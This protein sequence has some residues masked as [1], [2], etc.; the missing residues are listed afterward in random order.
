MNVDTMRLVD[1]WV[2]APLCCLLSGWERMARA[3]RRPGEKRPIQKI[4]F[5][6]LS[7]MG[8]TVSAYSAIKKVQE[9]FPAAQLY[10]LMFQEMQESIRL[11]SI[12]A[13]QHILT[14]PSK[15]LS[16]L[17]IGLLRM[18]VYLRRQRFDAVL[19]LE[20]FARNSTII[21]YLSGARLRVGFDAFHMEGLYR[22]GLL[23]HRVLYNH[24]QHISRNFLG[25]AQALSLDPADLPLAKIKINPA[26]ICLP[27]IASTPE[28]KQKMRARL[29]ALCPELAV[30]H[31][32]IVFNPNG[33]LLL[34]L[35]RWPMQSYVELGKRL[36]ACPSVALV[37]TGTAAER[38]DAD[39]ICGAVR[40]SRCIN[41]AGQTTLRE[42]ID[43][44]NIA[45]LLVSNDSGPPNFASLTALKVL[46]FFGPETP[47]CYRPLGP[48]VEV[49]YADLLCSPC[50]SAYNH[51]KSACTDNKCLQ[52][53]SVD[54]VYARIRQL[55]PELG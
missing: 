9:L 8:S 53:I 14:V 25:L 2:G 7:E 39:L 44:Y 24:L 19:D 30:A 23:T 35:R 1:K 26:D 43:L 48:H 33:S 32:I 5:I 20:L 6:Q 31:R 47:C 49:L 29:Q 45:D 12:I 17:V 22:G 42:L 28:A 54:Q 16:G 34:P 38:T 41:F 36:V 4:L 21:S 46:V 11:L 37:I 18:I 3:L 40:S 50:V 52:A 15:T 10:Y 55:N 51:R 13:E 27:V